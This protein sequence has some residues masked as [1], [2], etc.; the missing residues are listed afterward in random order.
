MDSTTIGNN[1]SS[2]ATSSTSVGTNYEG[3]FSL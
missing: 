1:N 3:K 2:P